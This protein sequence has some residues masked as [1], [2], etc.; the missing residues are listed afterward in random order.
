MLSQRSAVADQLCSNR[1][2]LRATQHSSEYET[3]MRAD[4]LASLPQ[5]GLTCHGSNDESE[6]KDK[7][8]A[9]A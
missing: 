7:S 5:V 4:L 6:G 3:A 8:P 1:R 9:R 2:P